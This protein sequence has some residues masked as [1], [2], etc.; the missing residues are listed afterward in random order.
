MEH[1]VELVCDGEG[2]V[3]LVE[4][5]EGRAQVAGLVERGGKAIGLVLKPAAQLD[6]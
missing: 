1:G 3:V 4:L 5:G 2:Q 6:H